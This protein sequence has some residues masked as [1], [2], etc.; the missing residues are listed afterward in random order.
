MT[1][2]HLDDDDVEHNLQNR[3]KYMHVLEK[4]HEIS[5]SEIIKIMAFLAAIEISKA[6]WYTSI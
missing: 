3:K 4:S 6:N 5:V 1:V 2:L